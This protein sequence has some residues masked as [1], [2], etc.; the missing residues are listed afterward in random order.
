VEINKYCNL[1]AFDLQVFSFH[2]N[3]NFG[4]DC[5]MARNRFRKSDP[6]FYKPAFDYFQLSNPC[7]ILLW[8][9]MDDKK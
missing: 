6:L 3:I 8:Y 1:H 2:P 4:G 7:I 5:S 9:C